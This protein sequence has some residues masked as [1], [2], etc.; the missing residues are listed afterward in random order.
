MSDNYQN[1]LYLRIITILVHVFLLGTDHTGF[2][3]FSQETEF[4]EARMALYYYT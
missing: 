2:S 1:E 4:L 3:F